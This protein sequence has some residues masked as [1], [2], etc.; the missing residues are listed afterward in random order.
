MSWLVTLI[1]IYVVCVLLFHLY[2]RFYVQ[3]RDPTRQ[4][5]PIV[6]EPWYFPFFGPVLSMLDLETSLK[7]WQTKYGDSFTLRL[8][9]KNFTF[10]NRDADLKKF[11]HAP[12]EQLSL[13][14]AAVVTIG[15]TTP[16]NQYLLEHSA[17]PYLQIIL[18]QP[19]LRTMMIKIEKA[20]LD[21]FNPTT[22][23][24]WIEHGDETVVNFM[25]FCY[26]LIIRMN[27][28]SFTSQRVYQN[29]VDEIIKIFGLLDSEK[30]TLNPFRKEL[31]KI[32]RRDNNRDKLWQRWIEIIKPDMDRCI[33]MIEEKVEPPEYDVIYEAVK[34]AK[35]E[36]E[37]R[38]QP[39][40]PRL[41]AFF[42]YMTFFPAQLNTYSAAGLLLLRYMSHGH[43]EIGQRMRAEIE[44]VT[45]NSTD[46]ITLDDLNDMPY[47]EACLY[48]VIRY[49][50]D[51]QLAVRHAGQDI[52][53]SDGRYVPSGNMIVTSMIDSRKLFSEPQKF[54]PDRHLPPREENKIDPYRIVPFGRGKHPCTGERY[55]KMQVKL[56]LI[57]L[58]KMC[59]ME[60]TKESL[61]YEK[62][63]NRKQVVGLS[64]PSKP[65]YVRISKRQG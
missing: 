40:T 54:D 63:I 42:V 52:L 30:Q 24:F 27:C 48:E 56:M 65:V 55:V 28:E 58:S 7:R 51:S 26:R 5:I 15:D 2:V 32:F 57:Y 47:I 17:V 35:K 43:D 38:G 14:R 16:E 59:Y 33:K 37:K 19:F 25:E 61:D 11:Y 4:Y 23:T 44:H 9:G 22:G 39:F 36:L 45:K 3:K 50:T 34:Q 49:S 18:S 1:L 41:V 10:I 21:Y 46:D 12:E 6:V 20:L 53:L 64:R 13:V 62:L 8:I 60:L 29:H 31:E